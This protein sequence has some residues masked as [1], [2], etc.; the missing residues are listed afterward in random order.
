MKKLSTGLA[1]LVISFGASTSFAGC[2]GTVVMGKCTGTEIDNVG[3]PEPRGYESNS[4]ARYEY[5]MSD[6]SDQ[7]EYQYDYDAQRR[8]QMNRNNPSRQLDRDSGEYGGGF[9]D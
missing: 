6:P 2:I 5:D 9:Y 8:D 7:I 3:T 1:A 4:G